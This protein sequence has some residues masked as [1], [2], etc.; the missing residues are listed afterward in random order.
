MT[1][2][3]KYGNEQ[4][5]RELF[6][7][8]GQMVFRISARILGNEA[9]AED[10]VQSVFIR[11]WQSIGQYDNKYSMTTWL[12]TITC[13]LCYDELRKR[14]RWTGCDISIIE[15]NA[16]SGDPERDS[17]RK[18]A[19][20]ELRRVTE[21]L[22]PKQRIVFILR[23]IEGMNAEE[24]AEATGLSQLQIKSNL[25]FARKAVRKQLEEILNK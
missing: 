7:K 12:R 6:L 18:E 10:M 24:V 22:P 13:R 20:R 23:E 21:S 17:I 4:A 11:A 14:S 3:D 8:Y 19:L 15:G 9:D 2:C 16:A 1:N 25:Y 5:F